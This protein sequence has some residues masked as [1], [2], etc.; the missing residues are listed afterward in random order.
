MSYTRF[1]K[2]AVLDELNRAARQVVNDLVVA[3][4]HGVAQ[5]APRDT[6]FLAET[7]KA[8][9]MGEA[10]QA[11]RVEKRQ[12]RRSGEAVERRS[13]EASHMPEDTAALHVAADY[14]IDAELRDPFIW[15]NVEAAA[16]AL[17]DV[18]AK[19]RV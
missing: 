10:G 17:P 3:V 18:V 5:D 2:R 7:V 19:Q 4:A 9:G 16:Q 15:P 1:N 13:N 8:I 11:A 14:A 12:S 6:E